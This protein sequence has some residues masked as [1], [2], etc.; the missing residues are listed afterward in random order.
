MIMLSA[1]GSLTSVY[2]NDSTI[3][4]DFYD[5]NL[6]QVSQYHK[7]YLPATPIL[8]AI[9]TLVTPV[10]FPKSTAHQGVK[11]SPVCVHDEP[12]M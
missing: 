7:F 11:S 6:C 5:Y 1:K 2:L 12:D 4:L 10:V 9:K 8:L 3:G